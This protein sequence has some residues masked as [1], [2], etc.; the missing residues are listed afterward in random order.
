MCREGDSWE[1]ILRGLSRDC[2]PAGAPSP[3]PIGQYLRFN[4]TELPVFSGPRTSFFKNISV[5]L[6]VSMHLQFLGTHGP[7]G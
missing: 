1:L 2:P 6:S 7:R 4:S 5:V 3:G